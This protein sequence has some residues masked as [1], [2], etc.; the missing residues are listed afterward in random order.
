[1]EQAVG[2]IIKDSEDS[3][4]RMK[5]KADNIPVEVLNSLELWK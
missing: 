5:R 3:L 2:E 4:K 1:M